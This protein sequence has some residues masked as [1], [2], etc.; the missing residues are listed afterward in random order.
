MERSLEE[1]HY[2]L[3]SSVVIKWFSDEE[4]SDKALAIREAYAEGTANI[5]CPDLIIYEISNALRYNK[6]LKE[7][8]VKDSVNSLIS[9][10]ITIVVP[11]KQIIELSISIAYQHGIT[12]YDASF[13]A[14]AQELNFNYVTADDKLYGKI[15]Q[16]SFVTLLKDLKFS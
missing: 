2:V 8:D 14:L 5:T 16:L 4:D 7:K 13:I 9:M 3:D 1:G 10:G 6:S 12:V 15:K 11:T